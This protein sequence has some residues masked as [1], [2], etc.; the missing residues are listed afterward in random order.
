MKWP[1]KRTQRSELYPQGKA[2]SLGGTLY[3]GRALHGNCHRRYSEDW[4]EPRTFLD[5]IQWLGHFNPPQ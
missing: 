1:R 4:L 2:L 3:R 5:L